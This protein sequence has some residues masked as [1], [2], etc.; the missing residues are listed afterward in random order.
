MIDNLILV[1]AEK[2]ILINVVDGELIVNAPKGVLDENL[3][4]LIK[5]NKAE[6]I[7][8]LVESDIIV[9]NK[10]DQIKALNQQT[11]YSL[12]SSQRRLWILSQFEDGNVAY[13]MSGVFIFE[14]NLQIVSLN[15]AFNE[16]ISRHEIL[17]TVFREDESGEVKQFISPAGSTNFSITLTD[18]QDAQAQERVVR[19]LIQ[20]DVNQGFDL[21]SGPLLR[22]GLYQLSAQ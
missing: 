6:L 11:S 17:R 16:L 22:A 20:A 10:F 9:E 21:S 3:I 18:L 7:T 8:Y 13:N 4:K 15:Y 1:L 14:G 12:S 19:E 5:G 2:G